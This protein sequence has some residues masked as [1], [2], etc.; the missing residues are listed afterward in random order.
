MTD[1]QFGFGNGLVKQ[2]EPVSDTAHGERIVAGGKAIAA[3][4]DSLPATS[5][6]AYAAG[7]VLGGKL[8][9]AGALRTGGGSGIIQDISVVLKTAALAAALD[10]V[11]FRADPAASTF[12]DNAAF[13]VHANDI[14]KV[15]GCI[16]LTKVTN[17]GGG[18]LYE[19]NQLARSIKL[20]SGSTLYGVLVWR[21]APT[22]GS[23]AD[24]A[25]VRAVVLAD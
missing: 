7:D 24:L 6:S 18:T 14:A 9:F 15:I 17:L 3:V 8:T 5:T 23:T 19:G 4:P 21:G 1:Y 12:T 25:A 11:L 2:F 20:D 10:I 16:S 22:L 13:A